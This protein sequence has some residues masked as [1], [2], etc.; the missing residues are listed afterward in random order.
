[1]CFRVTVVNSL[2][3]DACGL[4]LVGFLAWFLTLRSEHQNP[5]EKV[6]VKTTL[7]YKKPPKNHPK[8]HQPVKTQNTHNIHSLPQPTKT[9]IA[10][11]AQ[12]KQKT[13]THYQKQQETQT[14]NQ[15]Q[16]KTQPKK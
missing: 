6:V 10:P 11:C 3:A 5:V 9:N 7:L 15:T 14:K 1:M 8:N 12:V 16:P 13:S 2:V 4:N